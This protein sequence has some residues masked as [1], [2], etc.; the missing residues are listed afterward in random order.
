MY[1]ATV[2]TEMYNIK[3][4]M[5]L[6]MLLSMP[7][8][9]SKYAI[10]SLR[11][12]KRKYVE[13][14]GGACSQCGYK[15]SIAALD[16]HHPN[17][18]GKGHGRENWRSPNFKIEECILLCANCHREIEHPNADVIIPIDEKRS[19]QIKAGMMNIPF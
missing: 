14:L 4:N 7:N 17:G 3:F 15:K 6:N 9:S 10:R 1:L 11:L 13:Q 18:K 16:F 19:Q 12:K 2:V 8:R 5:M